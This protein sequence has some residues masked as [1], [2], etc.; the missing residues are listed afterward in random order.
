MSLIKTLKK[1]LQ[2]HK[3]GHCCCC[4][5]VEKKPAAAKPAKQPAGAGAKR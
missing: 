4:H 3:D 1:K 5:A 2:E